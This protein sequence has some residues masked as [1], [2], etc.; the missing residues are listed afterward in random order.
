MVL[1]YVLSGTV[2]WLLLCPSLPGDGSGSCS[3]VIAILC[4]LKDFLFLICYF[5]RTAHNILNDMREHKSSRPAISQDFP[6]VSART[7]DDS[8][9]QNAAVRGSRNIICEIL[10]GWTTEE[11]ST[12]NALASHGYSQNGYGGSGWEST[13]ESLGQAASEF[14]QDRPHAQNQTRADEV[15]G[16]VAVVQ[17]KNAAGINLTSMIV[18][19]VPYSY[20]EQKANNT[21][22]SWIN[23]AIK[24]T[25]VPADQYYD[26]CNHFGLTCGMETT[27]TVSET[28]LTDGDE[29]FT[30]GSDIQE[31]EP[32]LADPAPAVSESEEAGFESEEPDSEE[33]D[34]E[35]SD[36]FENEIDITEE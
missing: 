11:K 25:I 16:A 21:T 22:G 14:F 4:L 5:S 2:T 26:I 28:S 7:W 12:V 15:Y 24:A 34:I 20:E 33:I 17:Y 27:N 36:S 30:D 19:M 31:N 23:T 18:E 10:G 35:D 1:G 3:A 9:F 8:A 29:I 6:E 13:G 32:V